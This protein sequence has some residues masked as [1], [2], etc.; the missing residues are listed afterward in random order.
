[1]S[2]GRSTRDLDT[3]F[4]AARQWRAK[5][6]DKVEDEF[7][8]LA[9]WLDALSE[10]YMN[11]L[12]NRARWD[13]RWLN[14][15]SRERFEGLDSVR[16]AVFDYCDDESGPRCASITTKQ[17]LA[18]AVQ[19]RPATACV[20][21][22]MVS[23][24]SRFVIGALGHLCSVD[25]EF[26][27]EHLVQSGYGASDSGLKLKNAAWLNWVERE[28]RF[29]HH[30]LPG[31]G[32]R[33]EWNVPRRTKDRS[34]AHLRWGRLGLLN[35]LGRKGFHEDEI[36]KR[37]SDGRWLME[38]D[39]LLDKHGLLMTAHREARAQKQARK[40]SK[41][42]ADSSRPAEAADSGTSGRYKTANV[43]R[44]Y[45]TFDPLPR[46]P[47]SWWNRDL[48]VM[49][50]EGLSYWSGSDGEGRKTSYVSQ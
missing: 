48:R 3:Y 33:T 34:W 50:P 17:Q 28:T 29:R 1:M 38:Q 24:L 14:V 13:P 41:K 9:H 31:P 37:L 26:W 2:Y 4:D 10:L 35:Y 5:E 7:S 27:F 20:R 21:V 40:R 42:E 23:D 11:N 39:V 44:P 46:N 49:A 25:P 43:Y 18:V 15:T 19:D 16:M 47:T 6:P 12:D 32:Q 36:E 30:A 45:S 22:F 8:S